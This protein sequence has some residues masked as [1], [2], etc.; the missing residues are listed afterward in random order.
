MPGWSTPNEDMEKSR[1]TNNALAAA[2]RQ[3]QGLKSMLGRYNERNPLLGSAPSVDPLV[4]NARR[5]FFHFRFYCP[6][7]L[8]GK[9]PQI[10][11]GV[12]FEDAGG[13][14]ADGA[15]DYVGVGDALPA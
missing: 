15:F 8:T 10:L 9:R 3:Q 13:Y 11:V 12:G 1:N 2:Y 7:D 14:H 4:I 6:D 5:S